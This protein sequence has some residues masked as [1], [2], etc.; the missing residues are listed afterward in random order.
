[1]C[2]LLHAMKWIRKGGGGGFETLPHPEAAMRA[3]SYEVSIIALNSAKESF[4]S[5]FVL[6]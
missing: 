3:A 2:E 6:N 1:M 5:H 4:M